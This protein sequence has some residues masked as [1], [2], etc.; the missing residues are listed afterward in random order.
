MFPTAIMYPRG[1]S[2]LSVK[3]FV[4]SQNSSTGLHMK[5]MAN[6]VAMDQTTTAQMTQ[7]QGIRYRLSYLTMR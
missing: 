3:G 5:T 6:I 1:K 4:R 7:I 2:H